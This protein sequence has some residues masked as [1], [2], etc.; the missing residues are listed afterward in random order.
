MIKFLIKSFP[1]VCTSIFCDQ[2]SG[3]EF[4][5]VCTSI[6]CDQ[7]SGKEFLFVCTS[8]FCYQ[9]SFDCKF[10]CNGWSAL[11]CGRSWV[12]ALVG[13]HV[14]DHGFEHWSGHTKYYK[15]GICCFSICRLL[16]Q[17]SSTIKI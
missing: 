7:I 12:R 16:S 17:G 3:K 13:S 10:L 14:V 4:H 15:I 1:I 8:I 9:I 5:V 11:E 6:F 2:N